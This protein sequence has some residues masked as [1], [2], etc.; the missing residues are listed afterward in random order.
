MT[1]AWF[2]RRSQ[3]IKDE[4]VEDVKPNWL[5]VEDRLEQIARSQTELNKQAVEIKIITSS[6]VTAL[7]IPDEAAEVLKELTPVLKEIP[8]LLGGLLPA[9][10]S[11]EGQFVVITEGQNQLRKVIDHLQ[12]QISDVSNQIS[13]P[14]R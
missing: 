1:F 3:K 2:R 14:R 5:S 4:V 13:A 7:G 12:L 6:I 9:L 8:S 11:I 10:Q